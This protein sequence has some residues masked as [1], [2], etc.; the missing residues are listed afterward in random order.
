MH[1]YAALHRVQE[2]E[3]NDFR[4]SI[5]HVVHIVVKRTRAQTINAENQLTFGSE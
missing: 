5:E 4:R 3:M 1:K 2:V